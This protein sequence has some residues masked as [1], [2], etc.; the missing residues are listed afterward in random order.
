[1]SAAPA[2]SVDATEASE[3]TT[4]VNT[5]NGGSQLAL[6]GY[7]ARWFTR[8]IAY[9]LSVLDIFA[10]Y[11]GRSRRME[12][13]NVRRALKTPR[14]A[15]DH[16]LRDFHDPKKWCATST[17][18]SSCEMPSS[19]LGCVPK[20]TFGITRTFHA[21]LSGRLTPRVSVAAASSSSTSAPALPV[22]GTKL[23][24]PSPRAPSRASVSKTV[25]ARRR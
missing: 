16:P 11:S 7:P 25:E 21:S 17:A 24:P 23:S 4:C 5:S 14:R 1:M 15:P 13:Q 3:P 18:G 19:P 6:V 8:G 10:R 20:D 2:A 12:C 9:H 22:R